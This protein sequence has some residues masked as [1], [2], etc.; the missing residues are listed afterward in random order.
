MFAQDGNIAIK[1]AIESNYPV[2]VKLLLEKFTCEQLDFRSKV[3]VFEYFN[4]LPEKSDNDFIKFSKFIM[5]Q[6]GQDT[7]IHLAVEKSLKEVCK[8]LLDFGANPNTKNVRLFELLL[9]YL[10]FQ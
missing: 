1:L 5:M 4:L 3:F 7:P 8:I 10:K 9:G 6:A 2:V